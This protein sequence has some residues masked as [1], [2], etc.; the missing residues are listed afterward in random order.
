[1]FVWGGRDLFT[2]GGLA[3]GA[4]YEVAVQEWNPIATAS[5]PSGRY[6]HVAAWTGSQLL[7]YGGRAGSGLLLT[8]GARYDPA[9]ATWAPMSAG[10]KPDVAVT[11]A[12]WTGSK[13]P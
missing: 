8:D 6:D 7:V 5:A 10:A 1:M 9:S 13:R 2:G 12:A 3:D 4:S 11:R